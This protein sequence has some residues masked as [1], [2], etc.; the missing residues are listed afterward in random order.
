MNFKE[1][2]G[3]VSMVQR[4]QIAQKCVDARF[5][6]FGA[7]GFDEFGCETQ[8][9]RSLFVIGV[10]RAMEPD[11]RSKELCRSFVCCSVS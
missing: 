2:V 1:N 3:A 9:S 6:K 8:V 5:D 11:K 10:K 7:L 4:R